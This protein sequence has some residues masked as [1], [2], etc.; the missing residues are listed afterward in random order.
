MLTFVYSASSTAIAIHQGLA[1]PAVLRDMST[2]ILASFIVNNFCIGTQV[3][4]FLLRM[5]FVDLAD[6]V[7]SQAPKALLSPMP[8]H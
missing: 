6:P 1:L 4:K 2:K 8:I 3:G 7:P 5:P